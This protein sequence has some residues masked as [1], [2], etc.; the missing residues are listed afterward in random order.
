[1]SNQTIKCIVCGADGHVGCEHGLGAYR[2]LAYFVAKAIEESPGKSDRAI[3][4]EL[5]VSDKT[6]A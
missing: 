6:V 5:G 4:K 3:A 1:M 2:P